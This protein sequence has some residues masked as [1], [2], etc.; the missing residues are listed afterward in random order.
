MK[1]DILRPVFCR[2][3]R[4]E[5]VATTESGQLVFRGRAST[6]IVD[7]FGRNA[8]GML[9]VSNEPR[10]TGLRTPDRF[11][12]GDECFIIGRGR[13]FERVFYRGRVKTVPYVFCDGI[14]KAV[15][16]AMLFDRGELERLI[17]SARGVLCDQPKI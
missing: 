7:V 4:L 13:L 5:Y 9:L 11:K 12:H 6:V 10:T 14:D 1:L 2:G 17:A 8:Q 16:Y 3:R 15:T